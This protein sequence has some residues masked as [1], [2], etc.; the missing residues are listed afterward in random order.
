MCLRIIFF[1]A[2]EV[3]VGEGISPAEGDDVGLGRGERIPTPERQ[4][5]RE[6]QMLNLK[7]SVSLL[8]RCKMMN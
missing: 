8:K 1:S 2:W 5:F 7:L 6:C 4:M 3:P